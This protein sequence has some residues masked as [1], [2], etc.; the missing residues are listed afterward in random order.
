MRVRCISERPNGQ[1]A[2]Q[3]K[4][5]YR[6]GKQSFGVNEGAEYLVFGLRIVNG[7]I[8]VE[9]A[10]EFEQLV[11]VPLCLFEITDHRVPG[12]WEIRLEDNGSVFFWPPSFY[13]REYYHQDLLDQVPSVVT[14]FRNVRR[15]LEL[16]GAILTR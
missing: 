16:E 15:R 3:M 12:F 8:L 7:V 1:Q 9:I 10:Q 5:L 14:D 13:E 4:S 2:E 11:P 6:G